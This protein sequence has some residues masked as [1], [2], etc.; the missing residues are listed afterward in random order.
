MTR[1]SLPRTDVCEPMASKE[2]KRKL[3]W[4]DFRTWL[5]VTLVIGLV[6]PFIATGVADVFGGLL[7]FAWYQGRRRRRVSY[8]IHLEIEYRDGQLYELATKA[9]A[10]VQRFDQVCTTAQYI[11]SKFCRTCQAAYDKTN[12]YHGMLCCSLQDIYPHSP[13]ADPPDPNPFEWAWF[14]YNG[15]PVPPPNWPKDRPYMD[16]LVDDVDAKKAVARPYYEKYGNPLWDMGYGRIP[17]WYVRRNTNMP[18]K[19]ED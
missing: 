17:E 4:Y 16:P 12:V 19:K 11:N 7:L 18:Q 8:E 9:A 6:A 15:Y 5:G 2:V 13:L 3:F 10:A 14:R 1:V